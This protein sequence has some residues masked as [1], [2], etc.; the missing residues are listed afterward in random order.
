SYIGDAVS[1]IA[2]RYVSIYD[3][4]LWKTAPIIKDYIEESLEE[5]GTPR[6]INL[7]SVFQQGQFYYN[8]IV[9]YKNLNK[10][11]FNIALEFLE[12]LNVTITNDHM[13]EFTEELES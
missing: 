5:F 11:I 13:E 4:E 12:E 10:I 7:V 6:E 3:H 1:E 2:D 8:E 9:L